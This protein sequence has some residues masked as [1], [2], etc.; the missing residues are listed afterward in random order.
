MVNKEALHDQAIHLLGR[1]KPTQ[2]F[3]S[4]DGLQ[5]LRVWDKALKPQ[6]QKTINLCLVN[7][8]LPYLDKGYVIAFMTATYTKKKELNFDGVLFNTKNIDY[9][10][11]TVKYF[12]QLTAAGGFT[13]S[14]KACSKEEEKLIRRIEEL[15]N[16]K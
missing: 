3:S 1:H 5:T 16:S 11:A 8:K 14:M 6:A 2:V 9:Q 7:N 15:R 12:D 13:L 4:P 10:K